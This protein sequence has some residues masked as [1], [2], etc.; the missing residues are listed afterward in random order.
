MKTALIPYADQKT[1]LEAFVAYPSQENRPLVILCHTWR[2]RDEF[3]CDKAKQLAELGFVSFALDVYGQGILG[4]SIEENTALKKPFLEDRALLQQR[5]QC[6]ID[7]ARALA[8]INASR[9]AVLGYGFGGLCALDLA[10]TQED[11]KGAI[12]IYGHFDPL[13]DHYTHQIKA[14]VLI[15]HGYNDPISPMRELQAFQHEMDEA[16]IDW[17]THLY[18]NSLHAFANPSA[19]APALGILYNPL[20]ARRALEEMKR[21]LIEVLSAP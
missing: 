11:L 10:R 13:P 15:L 18:S 19:N 16:N 6:G 20:S 4:N 7:T 9:I 14:K 12:S 21:F 2:G 17:Q 5:L 1:P 8:H 3:I